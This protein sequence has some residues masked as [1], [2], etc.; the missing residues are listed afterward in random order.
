VSF[1][2]ITFAAPTG[3]TV[4]KNQPGQAIEYKEPESGA[5]IALS[6]FHQDSADALLKNPSSSLK[7]MSTN[8]VKNMKKNGF[9]RVDLNSSVERAVGE[10]HLFSFDM[11]CEMGPVTLWMRSDV[12]VDAKASRA[13]NLTSSVDPGKKG[14]A[15]DALEKLISSIQRNK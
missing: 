2:D 11:N 14:P 5:T 4:T 7:I 9:K 3:W 8:F 15:L 12:L 6:S 13:Y 10:L 1:L